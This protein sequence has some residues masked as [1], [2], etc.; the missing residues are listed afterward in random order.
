MK[1]P[2]GQKS[3]WILFS[4]PFDDKASHKVRTDAL[5]NGNALLSAGKAAE[6]V[7]PLRKGM[8][9]PTACWADNTRKLSK[10]KR[11]GS[12]HSM[13]RLCRNFDSGLVI[14]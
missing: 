6:A 9:F 10:V 4:Y 11:P 1:D 14:A 12:E 7:E 13:K 8:D 5:D 3:D 2:E